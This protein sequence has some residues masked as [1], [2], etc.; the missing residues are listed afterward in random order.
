MSIEQSLA[1]AVTVALAGFLL[2]LVC[3]FKC[4][5][6][7]DQWKC[8]CVPVFLMVESFDCFLDVAAWIGASLTGDLTF[9]DDGGFRGQH[10]AGVNRWQLRLVWWSARAAARLLGIARPVC[11]SWRRSISALRTAG[12]GSGG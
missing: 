4:A 3:K 6:G 5:H 7:K 2:A 10:L 12:L 1:I 9:S 8:G 11:L